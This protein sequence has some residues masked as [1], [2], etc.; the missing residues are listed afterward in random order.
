MKKLGIN[1]YED[2]AMNEKEFVPSNEKPALVRNAHIDTNIPG[3]PP[4]HAEYAFDGKS[5]TFFW[6]GTSVRPEHYFTIVL[7][8]PMKVNEV[9]VITGDSKDYITMADLLISEDGEKFV[10]V[11]KFD[12]LGQASATPD[13][14]KTIKAVKI[15]ITGQH[16][17]WPIIKEIIL[18]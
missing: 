17:C 3:N 15:Q 11:G 9:K 16:T 14:A 6:G 7:G 13:A 8:E 18:K 2:D 1:Y 4:Y 5:N 12:D 10:K